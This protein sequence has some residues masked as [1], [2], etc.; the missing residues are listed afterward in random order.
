MISRLPT[1]RK[2]VILRTVDLL[3]SLKSIVKS[4]LKLVA[5][6]T[7]KRTVTP[8]R[9]PNAELRSRLASAASRNRIAMECNS[10]AGR[11]SVCDTHCR[12]GMT[13]GGFERELV[14]VPVARLSYAVTPILPEIK[15]GM[16][17]TSPL[18]PAPVTPTSA[19]RNKQP[20]APH[21]SGATGSIR[22][23]ETRS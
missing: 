11:R 2:M 8:K 13:Q 17:L 7:V 18:P 23:T 4:H 3:R 12:A 21:K 6:P 16:V 15:A 5:P 9:R 19:A 20:M 10:I 1:V 22:A 14:P